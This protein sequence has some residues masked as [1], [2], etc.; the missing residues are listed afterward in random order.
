MWALLEN[1]MEDFTYSISKT[2]WNTIYNI[3]LYFDYNKIN[4]K[5]PNSKELFQLYFMI[6]LFNTL[7]L[8]K[9]R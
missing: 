7:N 1:C 2:A 5:E 6:G 8:H 9:K 4:F 3:K